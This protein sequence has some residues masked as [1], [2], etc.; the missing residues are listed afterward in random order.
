MGWLGHCEERGAG[1]DADAKAK[2]LHYILGGSRM[3]QWDR[4]RASF[5]AEGRL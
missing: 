4:S 2:E 1:L 5:Y 3:R